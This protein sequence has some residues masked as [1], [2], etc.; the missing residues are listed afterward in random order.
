MELVFCTV[1]IADFVNVMVVTQILFH[2]LN[3]L[4]MF[5]FILKEHCRQSRYTIRDFWYITQEL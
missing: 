2:D 5:D 1:L 3:N 4:I